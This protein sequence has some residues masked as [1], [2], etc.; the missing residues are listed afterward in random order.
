M[1]RHFNGSYSVRA[2]Y[3]GVRKTQ[4]GVSGWFCQ[5]GHWNPNTELVDERTS[6]GI[7]HQQ[8]VTTCKQCATQQ[9]RAPGATIAS[10]NPK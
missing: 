10:A 6:G 1:A 7:V 3:H 5:N 9:G 2:G 8:T 4:P